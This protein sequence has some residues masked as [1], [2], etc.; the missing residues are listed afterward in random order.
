M[1]C[2][3]FKISVTAAVVSLFFIL[4]VFPWSQAEANER[5]YKQ[6]R[7]QAFTNMALSSK[8]PFFLLGL[9][10][11]M[12][13]CLKYLTPRQRARIERERGQDSFSRLPVRGRWG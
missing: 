2:L 7:Q 3:N 10:N 6:C 9:A 1:K 11:Q 13:D 4:A 12:N 8:T 5:R